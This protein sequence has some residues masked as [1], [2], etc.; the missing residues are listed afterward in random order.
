[1]KMIQMV[2]V[3]KEMMMFSLKGSLSL[4]LV[5]V[6]MNKGCLLMVLMIDVG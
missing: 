2:L 4:V 5:L 3:L 6:L 1:M